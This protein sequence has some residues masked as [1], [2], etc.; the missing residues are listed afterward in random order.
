MP[1]LH[2]R[3]PSDRWKSETIQAFTGGLNTSQRPE[4][5][6]S[7]D[8]QVCHNVSLMQGRVKSDTG[9]HRFANQVRGIPQTDYQYYRR[10]GTSELI[11]VTT[12]TLYRL[13]SA[14]DEW[15]Y[16]PA[17]TP[18]TSVGTTAA[19][20]TTIEVTDDTGFAD[21]DYIGIPLDN[22]F[23]HRTRVNGTP[24]ANVITFDDAIPAGRTV[25]AGSAIVL[26]VELAGDL[27]FL[28]SI[29]PVP[30]HDWVA[31]TNGIDAPKYFDGAICADIPGL[32]AGVTSC[33]VLAVYNA[34]LF[35]MNT[36]E[37][38]LNF[39]QRIRRAEIG[40]PTT[41]TG[42]TT[43]YDDLYNG[44]D[45]IVAAEPMGNYLIVYRERSIIKGQYVNT[46]GRYYDWA[47]AVDGEGASSAQSVVNLNA[48]HLIFANAGIYSYTGGF[49]V[50]SVGDKVFYSI[51]S[52]SGDLN[53]Q[54]R[55]RIFSFYVEEL[56][57][58]WFF[59][60][61]GASEFCNTLMRY[62]IGDNSWSKR[63]FA[64]TFTGF[65]FYQTITASRWVDLSG[66]W[67]DQNYRWNSRS[68]SSDSP[69]THL[70]SNDHQ[71]VMEYNYIDTDDDDQSI[72]V[73]IETKDFFLQ[74]FAMR[75]D[76]LQFYGKGTDILVEYSTDAGDSY[77][78]LGT[79]SSNNLEIHSL[80]SQFVCDKIRFRI[81][82][83]NVGFEL[84]WLKFNYLEESSTEYRNG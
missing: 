59:Y 8:L 36:V 61:A 70:M 57:E 27:D 82:S 50:S 65:G 37:G 78:T 81:S 11:L 33:S 13:N 3:T 32:P 56:D 58:A 42:G 67:N 44:S 17:I 22:G 4:I 41:W 24:V 35:M 23:Q 77:Q 66:S 43:G 9:Y 1:R 14:S 47:F 62:N 69:T 53:T 40:D 80:F 5:M 19:G 39:P 55:T 31:F 15:D 79:V 76:L 26:A 63:V 21:N 29:V 10:T 71:F 16:V 68:V 6:S 52:S 7:E 74:D 20:A 49:D 30:S 51:F 48:E 64:D 83:S 25:P 38:G 45:F 73:I 75:F 34:T 72:D 2:T 46:A 12:A 60:P 28:V 84:G 18:P 54:Y